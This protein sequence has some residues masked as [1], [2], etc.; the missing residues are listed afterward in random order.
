[1]HGTMSIDR[2]ARRGFASSG[3][4]MVE[5]MIVVV[6]VS[7]IVALAT[8]SYLNSVRKSRRADAK[9]VLFD[10]AQRFE[11]C[12]AE[13]N[14]Y[15]AVCPASCPLLPVTSA[16]GNY[17]ITAG[18]GSTIAASA[19]TL[20]ATP[21]AGKPQTS[22]TKCTSFTLTHLNVKSATGSNASTCW[23]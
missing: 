15:T 21:V 4:T 10:T 19:F 8:N 6:V 16:G 5:L 22:D 18:G 7:I 2:V 9:M 20:V 12:F 23:D 1:M 17:A 11:R 14:S 3:F 13:C